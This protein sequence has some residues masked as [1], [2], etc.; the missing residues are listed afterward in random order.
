MI[1]TI[2]QDLRYAARALWKS[3][4]FTVIAAL[5]LALGVGGNTAIFSVVNAV[6]LRPL[7]FPEPDR[8][9][10]IWES[11]VERGR[12]TF[13][14][15]HPNF[16]DFRAQAGSFES[17]AAMNNAGFT[18]TSNGEADIVLGL[19]VT[20]TFLPTL[21]ISP[22]IGRNF[23]DEEDRPGGNTHVV[24]IG[25]GFW[26]RAFG[27]DP[28][29]VGRRITL[30]S[31]PYTII[32]VLPAS[33]RW[34]ESSDMLAPLAPDPARNR[35]DHRLAMIG[36][37]KSGTTLEQATTELETIAARLGQQY[38]ESNK[39][40]G[41]VVNSFYDWLVPETTRQSL[42]VLLG[43]VAL[44]LLIACVN[45]VNLLLARAAGRQRELSIRAAMGASRGRVVR[46]LLLE[47]SLIALIAA[48]GG[49]A[50]TFAA[51]RL[52][53]ALG[54][55][56][57]PRLEELSIDIRVIV[58]ATVVAL[59][60]MVVFGVL[61]AIHS[62][63]HDPQEALRADGR[64]STSGVGRKRVHAALTIGE[65]ALSVALLIGA[66]LLIRSFA[67]LQQ[68]DP[69]LS[70]GNVMTGRVNLSATAYPNGA[71]RRAFYDRFLTDL[72]GRPGVE[73]AAIS[74]GPPLAGDFTAGDVKLPA[75]SNEEAGSSAWR[76]A[77]P[78][79]FAALGIPLRG[80]EFSMQDAP[81]GPPVA[82][83]SAALAAKYF[84]NEDPIG[85]PL[86]MRSF[87]QEPHTI[88]GVAGDVKTFGLEDD[89]GFVFYGSATQYPTWNPMSLVWRA[90]GPHADAVAA[91]S[92]V[93]IVRASLRSIDPTVPLSA[94]SS[95]E[96]L[97]EQS[98]GPRRFNLY[99]LGAFAMVSLA[100]AAIGLF[101]VMA[102]LVSQRTR[103]IGVRL[104]LG[105][106]RGEVFRLIL[107]RGLALAAI[108]AVGGVGAALWL[109]RVMETLLF[110]VSRT[111]PITFV[112]V[113]VTVIL[114][115]SLACY[116]PARRAMKVDPVVALRGD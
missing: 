113:P 4:G 109:T 11:N 99:L 35:A 14:V 94:V 78:G 70:T 91:G 89:A 7:P 93:N 59:T 77:G 34:G 33:F 53:I 106:T 44:V 41:V 66:G 48:I 111:D 23:L 73:A 30:N 17:L 64:H 67:R 62:A 107:G 103:E 86:V 6:M 108:G 75:Q 20:A 10:R 76:L 38:P 74:S 1:S 39:G 82:I 87:R 104:A 42:L 2:L 105:A 3:P 63:R 114:V 43:A 110:S 96:T 83:I 90:T 47:S 15:S 81:D 79:Y 18:W 88:I 13:A 28:N 116:L 16:L 9:V 21:K 69:G 72:R 55:D 112:A 37:V 71:A 25:D 101:G 65:V 31:Q 80:R 40:W 27:G 100:L 32:G 115:A 84:P 60:T 22:V 24:L 29:A 8:L 52:L 57:V 51:T 26:R 5:T 85:K 98:L 68:V 49:L 56:S 12:P 97:F 50:I 58:F 36:R 45:V 95:M 92:S 54:P 19:Q 61:P 46:Q 102:Y